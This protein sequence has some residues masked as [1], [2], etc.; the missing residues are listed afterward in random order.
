MKEPEYPKDDPL[1]T[2]SKKLMQAI[3]SNAR[4]KL[5]ELVQGVL[6]SVEIPAG[7]KGLDKEYPVEKSL[8]FL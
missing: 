3:T 6:V 2:R 5:V 4:R 1:F 7:L 8:D